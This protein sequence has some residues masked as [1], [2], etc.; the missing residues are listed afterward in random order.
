MGTW[1]L[2]HHARLLAPATGPLLRLDY[3]QRAND[4]QLFDH[5]LSRT[6]DGGY[7]WTPITVPFPPIRTTNWYNEYLAVASGNTNE[8]LINVPDSGVWRWS[9]GG[10]TWASTPGRRGRSSMARSTNTGPYPAGLDQHGG[11]SCLAAAGPAAR[12]PP[13]PP[14]ARRL[15]PAE[16]TPA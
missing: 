13:D 7:S 8:Y 4:P 14:P 1:D 10:L 16:A 3:M 11:P 5:V 9:D 6:T 15:R 2:E 12:P